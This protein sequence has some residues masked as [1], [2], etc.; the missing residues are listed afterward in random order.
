[1]TDDEESPVLVGGEAQVASGGPAAPDETADA[2]G[3][4]GEQTVRVQP[5]ESAV[6]ATDS[7]QQGAETPAAEPSPAPADPAQPGAT[8]SPPPGH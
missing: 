8:T 6:P 7:Q 3:T 1:V 5:A 2:T 4:T